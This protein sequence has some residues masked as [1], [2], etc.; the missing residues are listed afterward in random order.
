[1]DESDND[2]IE[3]DRLVMV[4]CPEDRQKRECTFL[5]E[6]EIQMRVM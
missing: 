6:L 1:M 4:S 3:F 2:E 5:T